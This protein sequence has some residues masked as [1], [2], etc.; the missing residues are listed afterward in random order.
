MAFKC[1]SSQKIASSK[2][3]FVSLGDK[4][5]TYA[6]ELRYWQEAGV[7]LAA[8]K[9]DWYKD[10][11]QGMGPALNTASG[12]GAY[13]LADRGTWLSF[14]NRGDLAILVEGGRPARDCRVQG[15]RRAT[16]LPERVRGRALVEEGDHAHESVA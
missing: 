9:G 16:V 2:P 5:G 1:R 7:D 12:L 6:A 10:I 11:G 14:K 4:S 13:T 15:R 8:I 3:L